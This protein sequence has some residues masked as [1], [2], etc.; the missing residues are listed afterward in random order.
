MGAETEE[1]EGA[2]ES[3]KLKSLRVIL[4]FRGS[5]GEIGPVELV[6]GKLSLSFRTTNCIESLNRQLEIYNG[7]VSYWQNSKQRQ[8]WVAT[9]LLEIEGNLRRMKGYKHLVQLRKAMADFVSNEEKNSVSV[10]KKFRLE[11][12]LTLLG[13]LLLG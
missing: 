10:I 12:E 3:R 13:P 9:A 2:L 1:G 11:L 6:A 7:R 5:Q 4:P 8:H